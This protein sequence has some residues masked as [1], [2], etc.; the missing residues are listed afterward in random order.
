MYNKKKNL[1]D[2]T[3]YNSESNPSEIPALQDPPG[4]FH[5]DSTKLNKNIINF[6]IVL[7]FLLNFNQLR[8]WNLFT[9]NYRNFKSIANLIEIVRWVYKAFVNK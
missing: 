9:V 6:V 7:S 4:A 2:L 5:N 3:E 1:N 8:R